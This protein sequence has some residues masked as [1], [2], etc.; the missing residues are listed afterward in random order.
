MKLKFLGVVAALA[1]ASG[2]AAM[3]ATITVDE[4]DSFQKVEDFPDAYPNSSTLVDASVLGGSRK[5]DVT[6]TLPGTGDINSAGLTSLA[7]QGG[8]LNF[9]NGPSAKG[10]GSV[11]YG[12]TGDLGD[13]YAVSGS[14]MT[15]N[16]YFLF[17]VGTFDNSAQAQ[18]FATVVTGS[19]TYTYTEDL[20][21]LGFDPKLRF[22][23]FGGA[24]FSDVQTITFGISTDG[25][26]Y[27]A[28]LDGT[29]NSIQLVG[30]VPL[31]AGGVLLIGGLAGLGA[32]RRRKKA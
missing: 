26:Q 2:G 14:S 4:F 5:L 30:A 32:L 19:G 10:V 18:F 25:A 12:S 23:E 1:M 9:A 17:N 3:A 11:T 7:S 22:S 15:A 6:N 28:A 27:D 8:S 29:L 24:D 13:L 20:I 16:P 21:G 31:P